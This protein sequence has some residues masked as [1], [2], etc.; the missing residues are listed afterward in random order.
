TDK[1]ILLGMVL[2][3]VALM[4]GCT[5]N[6]QTRGDSVEDQALLELKGDSGTEFSGSCTVGDEEP[7]EISG[8]VPQSFTYDLDGKPLKCEITSEGNIEA[9]LTAGNTNSVQRFSGGTLNLTYEKGSI[10]SSVSS[11]SGSSRQVS[12]SSSQISSSSSAGNSAEEPSNVTSESRNVSGFDEVEL[13][14]VGNLSI[15][16]TG[17]V[18]LTVEA[19][20]D[21]LPKIRTEVENNR[22]IIGPEPNTS[23]QTTQPINYELTV[24]D[25]NA[26]N[27]S[28]S[29]SINAEDIS[30]DELAVTISGAGDANISGSVD[31]QAI[32]ISGSGNYQ[33]EGLES[34]EVKV[35]VGGSGSAVVN[36]SDELNAEVS[37]IGSVEYIGD[38]TINQD[39][40]GVGA[41][42]KR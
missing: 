9:N 3:S 5:G 31:T 7:E 38:P 2:L 15:Q 29:G 39:V 28:G 23:I 25:L 16:Q 34:K 33:A 24:N 12:S 20:E 40:S 37:G 36:V 30:T 11:S 18:S 41:V 1:A 8:Q 42:R 6:A 35:D 21:V 4:S 26:L 27:I 10:S 22:L 32:N 19:E 17:T 13:Q 14:G